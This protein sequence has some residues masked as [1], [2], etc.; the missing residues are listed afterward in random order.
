MYIV[1]NFIW[2]RAVPPLSKAFQ[3]SNRANATE[4]IKHSP[5]RGIFQQH[6]GNVIPTKVSF[7]FALQS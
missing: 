4:I 3:P 6:I 1:P 5:L 7:R 2:E